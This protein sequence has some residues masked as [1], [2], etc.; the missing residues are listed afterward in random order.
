MVEKS[1]LCKSL[2]INENYFD[3]LIKN[4][5]KYLWIFKYWTRCKWHFVW[6]QDAKTFF[7]CK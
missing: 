6:K 1:K 2:N 7:L 5:E 3:K 4:K